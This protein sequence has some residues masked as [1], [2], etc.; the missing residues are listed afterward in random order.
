MKASQRQQEAMVAA[1]ARAV[2]V[3]GQLERLNANRST[4]D[5]FD[6]YVSEGAEVVRLEALAQA[7][8]DAITFHAQ[9]KAKAEIEEGAADLDREAATAEREAAQ[10]ARKDLPRILG[11]ASELAQALAPLADHRAR[12]AAL[13][14]RLRDANKPEIENGEDRARKTEGRTT[15]ARIEQQSHWV[16]AN[17]GSPA[18][19]RRDAATGE[20]VPTEAGCRKITGP[21]VVEAEQH[22]PQALAH[23]YVETIV[24]PGFRRGDAGLWPRR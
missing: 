4:P 10:V 8:A 9:A 23:T 1:Q 6:R 11:L 5:E 17:G 3:A 7:L 21:V 20:L 19:Y 12:I 18:V 24:I 16:R 2:A 15:P 22:H 13:N 14:R